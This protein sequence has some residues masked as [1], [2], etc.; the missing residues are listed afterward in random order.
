MTRLIR[1]DECGYEDSGL[2][3][4]EQRTFREKTKGFIIEHICSECDKVI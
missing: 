4:G 3:W 2:S 1:C